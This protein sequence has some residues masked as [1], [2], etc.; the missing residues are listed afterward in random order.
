MQ[1]KNSSEN[2][3]FSTPSTYFDEAKT[4]LMLRSK[5]GGF[6]VPNDYFEQQ[7]SALLNQIK[8][9][10]KA[11]TLNKWWYGVAA[12]FAAILLVVGIVV[13]Q[14]K[15]TETA[16]TEEEIITYVSASSLNDVPLNALVDQVNLPSTVHDTDI[17]DGLDEEILLTDL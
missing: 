1:P 10:Q 2:N 14:P 12:G 6:A 11:I 8:P 4:R 7:R 16:L 3:G 9:K 15:H 17:V 5:Q 13:N